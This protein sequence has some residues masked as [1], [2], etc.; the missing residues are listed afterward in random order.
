MATPKTFKERA[1]ELL[2]EV[3]DVDRDGRTVGHSYGQICELLT[4][5]FPNHE[6][7]IEIAL[8]WYAHVIRMGLV[9]GVDL[10]QRRPITYWTCGRR[11]APKA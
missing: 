3:V 8:R 1:I 10:P 7:N 5:E 11:Q 9:D 6:W 2:S 4:A